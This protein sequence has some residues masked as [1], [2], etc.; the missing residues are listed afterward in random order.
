M[1]T[2]YY[3]SFGLDQTIHV[4]TDGTVTYG[5]DVPHVGANTSGGARLIAA[6]TRVVHG[7]R[8]APSG[9]PAGVDQRIT[10]PHD[11]ANHLRDVEDVARGY[12]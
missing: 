6:P 3:E 8:F 9:I 7:F 4:D 12:R 2:L 11:C 5:V 1:S 10:T